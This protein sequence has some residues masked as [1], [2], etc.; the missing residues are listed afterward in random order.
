MMHSDQFL[1]PESLQI[2]QKQLNS[3]RHGF[4]R[5]VY[6]ILSAQLVLTTFVASVFTFSESWRIWLITSG[7]WLVTLSAFVGIAVLCGLACV[8]GVSE[9]HPTNL[10]LLGVF[11]LA[12][13]IGLGAACAVVAASYGA[14][15]VLQAYVCTA[16][17][18]I[19]LTMFAMQTKYDFTKQN[20]L[21][22]SCLLGLMAF[23]FL[24]LLFPAS[25]FFETLYAA[26]GAILFS[27]YIVV[28]TQTLI[29][30]KE[31]RV[32]EDQYIFVA[33]TLYVDIINLFLDIL[34]LMA[35]SEDNN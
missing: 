4:I 18:V 9:R 5:K 2:D 25:S 1:D 31:L 26:L 34:R 21:L 28:D 35:Q 32:S 22:Y 7:S 12:Q 10:Y 20:G 15:V 6:G 19:G 13:S 16:L 23:G 14:S 24:R 3:I 11:T 17:I 27:C 33:L 30:D 8:P 29:G